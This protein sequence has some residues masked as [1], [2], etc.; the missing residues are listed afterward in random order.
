MEKEIIESAVASIPRSELGTIQ[1][2]HEIWEE[3]D[4]SAHFKVTRHLVPGTQRDREVISLSISGLPSERRRVILE[5]K[6]V[7]GPPNSGQIASKSPD[8]VDVLLWVV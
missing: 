4:G 5:F 6:A 3:T 8:H 1:D 7:F 2:D